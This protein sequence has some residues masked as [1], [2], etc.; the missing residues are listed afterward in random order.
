MI[1]D[2][3]DAIAGDARKIKFE[4]ERVGE[5]RGEGKGGTRMKRTTTSG[6][7]KK[8]TGVAERIIFEGDAP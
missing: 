2:A 7:E 8:G 3:T 1:I 5:R 6:K 4:S